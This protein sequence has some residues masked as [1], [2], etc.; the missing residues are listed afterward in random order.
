MQVK[1]LICVCTI[2]LS[3][4]ILVEICFI[5]KLNKYKLQM[6][7]INKINQYFNHNLIDGVSWLK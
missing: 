1:Q 6:Q 7:Y 4:Y 5:F 3:F 2:L